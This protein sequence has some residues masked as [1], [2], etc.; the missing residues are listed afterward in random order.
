M[1]AGSAQAADDVFGA[2]NAVKEDWY[3]TI[4]GRATAAPSYPG[5]DQHSFR[6]SLIFSIARASERNVFHS[7]DDTPSIALFNRHGFRAGVAGMIDWGRN[8]SDSDRLRGVGTIGYS[9]LAGGFA[10]WYPVEWLR[11]RAELLYGMGGFEG[12]R[13]DVR[14]DFIYNQ[15][16]WHFAIGP[17]LS[18]A[19]SDYMQ[20]Y[21]GVT[22]TQAA[23]ATFLLNPM[24]AYQAGSGFDKVGAT[25]QLSYNFENGITAGVYGT[26]GYLIGDA[27][28]SPLV[29][30]RN[31]FTTGVTLSY[32]F[33]MGPGLW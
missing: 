7:V 13:G 23:L 21:Y 32:T 10:E 29:E 31:Q 27:A 22:A 15:G 25:A 33:N 8:E 3:V 20:T 12:V 18:Y 11:L 30:D 14:A 26:Y 4:G 16:P 6:P 19:G 2:Q 1:A 24:S 5:A 17:R 9:V 28:D